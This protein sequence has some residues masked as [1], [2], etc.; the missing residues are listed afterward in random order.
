M[1]VYLL[2]LLCF[3]QRYGYTQIDP[4]FNMFAQRVIP[5]SPNAAALTKYSGAEVSLATGMVQYQIPLYMLTSGKLSLP[6][7]LSYA[8]NG[9]RVNEYPSLTGMSWILNAGGVITR[10]V[11]GAIDEGAT[12][13]TLA[14]NVSPGSAAMH[15]YIMAYNNPS[16]NDAND[17][18]PDLF[19]Y[20]FLNQNGKFVLD[21]SR[22]A[23]LLPYK[24]I[25]VQTNFSGTNYTFKITD[26]EGVQYFFGGTSATEETYSNNT[27]YANKLPHPPFIKTSY[28]L[29]TIV[30]PYGDSILLD[31]QSY[32]HKMDP[33]DYTQV[34]RVVTQNNT[35]TGD[36]AASC[37]VP[38]PPTSQIIRSFTEYK[39]RILTQIRIPN[40]GKVTFN[41]SNYN[42]FGSTNNGAY[43][44]LA[45]INVKDKNDLII[46]TVSLGYD[47]AITYSYPNGLT[48]A[49]TSTRRPFLSTIRNGDENYNFSYISPA[50]LPVITSF[51]QDHWG[52][53]NGASNTQ[54]ISN[55]G[56]P[57]GY[58]DATANRN[59][60]A[61][62]AQY[63]LLREI[64]HPTGGIDS[65]VY[66]A[67][68][69]GT[70][71]VGGLRVK[72]IYSKSGR[73]AAPSVRRIYYGPTSNLNL[74]SGQAATVLLDKVGTAGLL[75]MY[76]NTISGFS[77]SVLL[78]CNYSE[79]SSKS[80]N[81][82]HIFNGN[83]IAYS[84]VTESLGGD[85]FENGGVYHQYI[86]NS[87]QYSYTLVNG[88]IYDAPLY[89]SSTFNGVERY[90]RSF[91]KNGSTEIKLT[92]TYNYY[93]VS[94]STQYY[95][96]V[97]GLKLSLRWDPI[98]DY[99]FE[100]FD[101]NKTMYESSWERLDSTKTITYDENG[102]N[103]LNVKKVYT[104]NN[105]NHLGVT[106][107]QSTDS[108]NNVLVTEYKYPI[109]FVTPLNPNVYDNMVSKNMVVLPL[110][111]K[112][113]KASVL[114]T[115]GR[116]LYRL[117]NQIPVIDSVKSATN[118]NAMQH[119]VIYN[120][121]DGS[122]KVVQ[123]TGRD[124]IASVYIY[125]YSN[126][127]PIAEIR[128]ASQ[129]M[130]AYTSFEA[131]GKGGWTFTGNS[132]TDVSSPT[133]KRVYS[134]AGFP[135]SKTNLPQSIYH[136]TYWSNN[137][138]KTVNGSSGTAGIT[139]NGWTLY[140]HQLSVVGTISISG[141]GLLDEVRLYPHTA[142]MNTMTY[143][144]MIGISSMCDAN[145]SIAYYEYDDFSRLIVVRDHA[146]RVLKKLCY[147]YYNNDEDCSI[148]YNE[149]Q[150]QIFTRNNCP[151]GFAGGQVTYTVPANLYSSST[152]LGANRKALADI[153]AN[154]QAYANQFGT[155]TSTFVCT[156]SN[157]SGIDK[158]CVNNTC[159]TGIKVYTSS[160][161]IGS[162]IY[163]CTYHYEWSDGSWSA[164]YTEQSP[165]PCVSIIE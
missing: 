25:K 74:N 36:C 105:V 94:P 59:P 163:E 23:V 93:G 129:S 29:H 51:S 139:S 134:L 96:E 118:T 164:N 24:N 44:I 46:K 43:K 122:G 85:A 127:L 116:I 5:S 26:G 104:Y 20:N 50:D 60:N 65:L 63:G 35:C 136:V 2:I 108:R 98:G 48:N 31:Y 148:F 149:I 80:V 7:S 141:T 109:D 49:P 159:Q 124:G 47:Y 161:Q 79:R 81:N 120:A 135:L 103:P 138:S 45:D 19:S 72:S 4:Q 91:K 132:Q 95:K 62:Y 52:F 114:Q 76:V 70:T 90:T 84:D 156:T 8:S 137:G 75:C 83:I 66:E 17:T 71:Q 145:N 82:L 87:N 40:W 101:V 152:L 30:N 34:N 155:C 18:E 39:D 130:V 151:A 55:A 100:G 33:Q 162:H 57:S 53:Y 113:Y 64:T 157:C 68:M 9:V 12:R 89:Q 1:R 32:E 22:N 54:F 110:E 97:K 13:R 41:Y 107:V 165:Y 73:N 144:P 121:Y 67:N 28:Y 6:L 61:T 111:K 133:G 3:I 69:A 56:T 119:D 42:L 126:Q 14:D 10:T 112:E 58:W 15:A 143:E 99:Y 131:E 123:Y 140:T 16:W 102:L 106:H 11:N 37:S 27:A 160:V 158:K 150:S 117:N 86:V 125:D 78:T 154:G 128:G 21:S 92:E 38:C 153:V 146:K 147:N 142:L 115:T 77:E 88:S